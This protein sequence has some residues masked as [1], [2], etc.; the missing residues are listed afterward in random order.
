MKKSLK[1]LS[2]VLAVVMLGAFAA[3]DSGNG[4]ETTAPAGSSESTP[5]EQTT[6]VGGVNTVDDLWGKKIGVQLGTTGATYA[7]DYENAEKAAEAGVTDLATVERYNKGADA[8]LALTQNKVDCVIID[9]E[10]AKKF[11]EKNPGLAILDEPFA[12]EEYAMALKKGSELKDKINTALAELKADG[13]IEAII[14][15]YIGEDATRTPYTPDETLDRS[16]GTIK[17]ATNAHFEPYE[18]YEG[19]KVVGIDVDI[20]NAICDKLNMKLEIEDMEFNAIINAVDS[21]KC[22]I[23]VAGM[24]VTEERLQSVDFTDSYTTATQVIIVNAAAAA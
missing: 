20:M 19:E 21:G 5:A 8:V 6:N 1:V 2:L 10:P 24:T 12:V 18:Y 14:A 7:E 15:N 9:N 13:K 4:G 22:D 11:V 17:M 3:C 16:A 23:G